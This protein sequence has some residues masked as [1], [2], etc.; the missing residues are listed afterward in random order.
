M[1]RNFKFFLSTD[2]GTMKFLNSKPVGFDVVGK[3]KCRRSKL[4]HTGIQTNITAM[5]GLEKAYAFEI[6]ISQ[7]CA[8]ECSQ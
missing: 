4:F 7:L 6:D 8:T 1:L 2:S 5:V 3:K